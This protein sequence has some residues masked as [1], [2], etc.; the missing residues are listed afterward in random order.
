MYVIRSSSSENNFAHGIISVHS[1]CLVPGNSFSSPVNLFFTS[2]ELFSTIS[3][4]IACVCS[5]IF[6]KTLIQ[7]A[8]SLSHVLLF[9]TPWT[10]AHQAS[11]CITNSRSLTKL[12][13]I[14]SVMPTNHLILCRPLLLLPPIF[15]KGLFKSEKNGTEEEEW[16]WRTYLQGSN[17]ETEIENRHM[18]M[19]RGEER[20]RKSMY[21]KS[22]MENLHYHM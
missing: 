10:A 18:N 14:E 2:G 1:F 9:V 17:G 20:V 6:F 8:Q 19:G 15:P 3:L 4:K 5:K 22:N 12:M 11:L 21:G 16:Y 13:C 7:S